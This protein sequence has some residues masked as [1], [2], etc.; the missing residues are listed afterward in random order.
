MWQNGFGMDTNERGRVWTKV[1]CRET[2]SVL[3]VFF[4]Q[5]FVAALDLG[6]GLGL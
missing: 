3:E 1:G 2:I 5:I 4:F 6:C